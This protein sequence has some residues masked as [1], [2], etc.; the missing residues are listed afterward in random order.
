VQ[1]SIQPARATL[2]WGGHRASRARRTRGDCSQ[3]V[4]ITVG[5]PH[6]RHHVTL[7][8]MCQTS[9]Y[10][11]SFVSRVARPHPRN[12]IPRAAARLTCNMHQVALGSGVEPPWPSRSRPW[13]WPSPSPSPGPASTVS[14]R[15]P[16]VTPLSLRRH[17]AWVGPPLPHGRPWPSRSRPWP[18]PSPSHSPGPAL[19]VSAHR[20]R[21]HSAVTLPGCG[22]PLHTGHGG[23]TRQ[24]FTRGIHLSA[25]GPP[26]IH[27]PI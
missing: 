4:I 8:S 10:Q 16:A 18:W 9:H 5:N 12:T 21:R 17:S 14:A 26:T 3:I 25:H 20:P 7:N 2:T 24:C 11:Y 6:I 1:P 19:T 22:P 23:P 15:R 27:Q 13:P